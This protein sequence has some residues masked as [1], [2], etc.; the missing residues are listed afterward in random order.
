M[1][2]TLLEITGTTQTTAKLQ[3]WFCCKRGRTILGA[4]PHYA[5]TV[6]C[7]IR[8]PSINV[9]TISAT[10]GLAYVLIMANIWS[11]ERE[12]LKLSIRDRF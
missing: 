3:S 11:V 9:T 12:A 2:S 6:I 10:S 1:I 7:Q 5:P 4:Q 8:V